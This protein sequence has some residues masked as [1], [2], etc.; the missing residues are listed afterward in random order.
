[1][2]KEINK[3]YF[4]SDN[5]ELL[6]HNLIFNFLTQSYWAKG[7]SYETVKHSIQNSYCIGIYNNKGQIGFARLIT[8]YATFAYLADV[9]VLEEYRGKG[10]AKELLNFIVGL[11]W[12]KQLRNT[13]FATKDAHELY[14][15]YGFAALTNP[16]LYMLCYNLKQ[17]KD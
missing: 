13:M 4:L 11:E 12:V 6:N 5:K 15:P 8:D 10:L 2:E 9:F 16:K 3:D 14:K 7:I 17:N 1:M